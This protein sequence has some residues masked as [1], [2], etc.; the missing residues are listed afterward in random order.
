MQDRGSGQNNNQTNRGEKKGSEIDETSVIADEPKMADKTDVQMAAPD[1]F[2]LNPTQL[3]LLKSQMMAF[4]LLAANAPL[5]AILQD[6]LKMGPYG[7]ALLAKWQDAHKEAFVKKRDKS[8]SSHDENIQM[9][10]PLGIKILFSLLQSSVNNSNNATSSHQFPM[11]VSDPM[12]PTRMILEYE[13]IIKSRVEHR[14]A[15]L[16]S[17]PLQ[18]L[19]DESTRLKATIELK[20]LSL[21]EKQRKVEKC[22][23]TYIYGCIINFIGV[24]GFMYRP[25]Y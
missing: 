11:I 5:P 6:R 9:N 22:A 24:C 3:D 16:S 25:Y 23:V 13:R 17:M 12:D 21:L 4:K 15:Q 19:G 7:E 20:A 1:S 8:L 18:G 2:A 10:S 14:I